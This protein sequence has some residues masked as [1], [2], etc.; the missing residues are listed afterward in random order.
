MGSVCLIT[1]LYITDSDD[2]NIIFSNTVI[3]N[4]Q[5]DGIVRRHINQSVLVNFN[6]YTNC[7]RFSGLC[8]A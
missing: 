4:N 3:Q 6:D 7:F 2:V 8:H 1:H 5:F